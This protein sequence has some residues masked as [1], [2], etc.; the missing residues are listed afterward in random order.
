MTDKPITL[1]D[2]AAAGACNNE[3][4]LFKQ[5]FGEGGVATLDLVVSAALEFDWMFAANNMLTPKQHQHFKLKMALY[6]RG[7]NKVNDPGQERR[8][9]AMALAFYEAYNSPT[10]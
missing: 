4:A 8:R 2:L 9:K 3:T 7:L 1:A 5:K 10:E 6:F